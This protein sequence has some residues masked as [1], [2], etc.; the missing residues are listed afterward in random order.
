M[1]R[2]A[3]SNC[4]TSSHG[5]FRV[6]EGERIERVVQKH[7]LV[8]LSALIMPLIF[9]SAALCLI[10][11]FEANMYAIG[12]AL[13]FI[14]FAI[15][16]FIKAWLDYNYDVVYITNK[17][18]ILQNRELFGAISNDV[19]YE[20]ITNVVP[21]NTGIL[22]WLFGYGN[23][24]I[25]TASS[26]GVLLFKDA[27]HPHEI[28]RHISSNRQKISQAKMRNPENSAPDNADDAAE[29]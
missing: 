6:I 21:N 22:H 5:E 14:F 20:A 16:F 10:A 9:S 1:E 2:L 28:V 11:F 19:N 17:R 15:I 13:L 23:L 26:A 29:N 25:E 4:E 12:G 3:I 24:N 7:P 27:P 18:I 8:L